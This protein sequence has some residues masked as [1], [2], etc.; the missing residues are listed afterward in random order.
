MNFVRKPV[1]LTG[2]QLQIGLMDECGGL[3]GVI[4]PLRA[5]VAGRNPVQFVIQWRQDFVECGLVSGT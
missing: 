4:G 1:L 3:Q 2:K 5:Q